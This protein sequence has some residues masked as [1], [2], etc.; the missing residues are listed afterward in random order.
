[1]DGVE[2]ALALT[3]RGHVEPVAAGSGVAVALRAVAGQ[4]DQD[5]FTVRRLAY[6][7]SV[8]LVSRDNLSQCHASVDG[9]V[10]PKARPRGE[11][12]DVP[13]VAVVVGE[14]RADGSF[15]KQCVA[16]RG[17]ERRIY[18]TEHGPKRRTNP[19]E[20]RNV[21]EVARTHTRD[22]MALDECANSTRIRQRLDAA[23]LRCRVHEVNDCK[24]RVPRVMAERHM[25]TLVN[26]YD[27]GCD[28]RRSAQNLG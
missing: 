5:R 2:P 6:P 13:L 12:V 17:D 9:H 11:V 16:S 20:G 4:V 23:A 8:S 18:R 21:R 1:M 27:S 7:E 25:I 24:Q 19:M 28:G 14:P 15:G 26:A 3:V 22:A 10:F